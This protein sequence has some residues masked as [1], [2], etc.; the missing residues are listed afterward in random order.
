MQGGPR[1]PSCRVRARNPPVQG[2]S[3]PCLWSLEPR[4]TK[5]P[6]KQAAPALLYVLERQPWLPSPCLLPQKRHLSGTQAP[7]CLPACPLP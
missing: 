1:S 2:H 3:H 7:P 6:S 4:G 5:F